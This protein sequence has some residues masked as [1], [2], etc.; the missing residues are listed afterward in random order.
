MAVLAA[1]QSMASDEP[2][3]AGVFDSVGTVWRGSSC[4]LR[5]INM[6]QSACCTFHVLSAVDS[7]HA[8][9]VTFTSLISSCG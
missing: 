9:A 3:D 5:W 4:G 6:G 1:C 2:Q 7:I 8:D